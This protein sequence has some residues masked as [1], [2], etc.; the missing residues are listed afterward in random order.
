VDLSRRKLKLCL[1]ILCTTLPLYPQASQTATPDEPGSVQGIVVSD[2]TGQPLQRA[3][4]AF[5]PV[6]AGNGGLVQTTNE[7]GVFSF[8]KVAPGRYSITVLRDG[9]LRQSSGRIGAYKMSPIFSVRG[10]DII[11][12]FTFRMT[13]SCV[14]SG[15][16]KFD[17][18]EPAVNV[19]IQLYRGY[20]FHG[21]HGYALAASTQ[22]NDRGE[23]RVHGLEPGSY[24]V[25]ALY[26]APPLPPDAK[27]QRNTD[28]SGNP[29]PELSYAVTFFPE[30]QKL[31]DAVAVRPAP[32][33]EVAGIDIFLTLV[34]TVHIRGR[35]TSAV[36]GKVIQG[37]SITLRWN[38]PD[39]TGS[40]SAPVN[41]SFDREQNFEI[42]GVTTGPY[43][44]IVTG[45]DDGKSVSARMPVSVGDSDIA[46]LDIVVGPEQIWKGKVRI[47]GGDDSTPLSGL[48]VSLEPR[49]A[50]A[51]IARSTVDKN[52][53]FSLPFV[54]QETY[55][56]FVSNAPEDAY[57]KSVRVGSSDRLVV[58][59]E[60]EPGGDPPAMEV[61]LNMNGGGVAGRVLTSDPTVVASG[62][63]VMLIPDPQAGRVQSYKTTIADE[64]GD[65]LA[66]GLA[67]GNYVLLAWL[68]QPPCE[69]YNPDDLPACL[70][71]GVRVQLS[72]G[73]LDSI[74]ITA[75]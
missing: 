48:Q 55:D 16:V 10:G 47:E 56:L 38:D 3:Q 70:A 33:Q 53:N 60:A 30:V 69:I 71:H 4:V 13:P 2:A 18:A 15:K 37:P 12:S 20:Y 32:G 40:V 36:S 23:Y 21:R 72:E 65:F 27:E 7:T 5:R 9:Y 57:L 31:A 64:F 52:G 49:R 34:H 25:A 68:D 11:R 6:E 73:G 29:S 45:V 67:P 58:G 44:A 63:T 17:D 46:N 41:V 74:Q 24:Y 61:V 22:T 19:T 28:P 59:L 51:P 42:R 1:F 75:T 39:N 50:L 66:K 54:P 35:V 62:A 43:L 26:Q 8:P 14:V